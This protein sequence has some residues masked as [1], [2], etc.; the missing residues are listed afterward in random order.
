MADLTP[1]RRRMIEDMTIRNLSPATQQSYVHAVAKFSRFFGRSPDQLDLEDV[2]A[3]QVQLVAGGVY[4]AGAE[5]DRLRAPFL[6]RA[7]AGSGRAAGADRAHARAAEA[8]GGAE[9]YEVVCFLEGWISNTS[10]GLA[11]TLPPA[12][13]SRSPSIT[14]GGNW[15]RL[16]SFR[17]LTR[18]PS[19]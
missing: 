4:L 7:H 15:P 13:N 14:A 5:P 2:R 12:S 18:L 16:A 6:L 3:F 17:F 8:A 11:M 1:L 19:R 10:S 9:R